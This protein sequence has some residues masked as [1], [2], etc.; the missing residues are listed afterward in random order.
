MKISIKDNKIK[1]NVFQYINCKIKCVA[2]NAMEYVKCGSIYAICGTF[3]CSQEVPI[4]SILRKEGEE[5]EV[6]Q[7]KL[8]R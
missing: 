6:Q 2:R 4:S 8:G 3:T 1:L 5:V 7:N